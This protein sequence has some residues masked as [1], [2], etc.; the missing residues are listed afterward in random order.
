[1][2]AREEFQALAQDYFD[3]WYRHNPVEASWLGIHAYDDLLGD[4]DAGSLDDRILLTAEYLQRLLAIDQ[5]ELGTEMGVDYDL[6][7]A[8][9]RATLWTLQDVVDWRRNPNLY[10]EAPLV[11]LLVLVSRDYAPLEERMRSAASRLRAAGRVLEQG[12]Q[13]VAQ[14]PHIFTE[15]AMQTCEG[16]LRFLGD[17]IPRLAAELPDARQRDDLHA[18]AQEAARAYRDYLAYLRDALLPR[19]NGGFAV[20]RALY[21]RRLREWHF[22]DL[23][24]DEMAAT[25][26]RLMQET[27]EEL[28]RVAREIDPRRSWQEIVEAAKHDTPAADELLDAYRRE[29]ARLRQFILDR[30]FVSIPE[31]EELEVIETPVFERAIVP[32]A[33]YMPPGPF[34]SRQLGSFWVTPI[35]PSLPPEAQQEQLKEHC[36]Y[37]FPIT[38]LHE[39]YPGHHLQLAFANLSAG[40]VRKHFQ[41]DLCAEGWAFYC[42][43]LMEE[44]G[45][46][47][48]RRL[49]LFQL[50]DQLWRS[51][52]VYIDARLQ[53]GQMSVPEAVDLLVNEAYLARAQAEGEVRRYTMTPTQPMTYAMGKEQILALR[54]EFAHLPL[55]EFHDRLLS[56]GTIPFA[57][58]A[59]ELRAEA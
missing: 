17:V 37:S 27:W 32:Y 15:T 24:A 8:E 1:M 18:A 51:A 55:R 44:Q 36:L 57:L 47:Q 45:Y 31:G 38:A 13:N 35:D 7:A 28:E 43:Q 12:I 5:A 9:L 41:S 11:G 19:S 58:T 6:I 49:R 33:A 14:P 52:R 54:R 23:T 29:I 39:A 34:E 46:Y 4:Y 3:T 42:E 50:K 53:T 40:Y 16:G 26:L 21:E 25:G 56:S 22:L 30:G 59:R 20:G 48:D 2:G 10:A